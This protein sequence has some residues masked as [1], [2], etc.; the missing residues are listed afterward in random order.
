MSPHLARHEPNAQ[1]SIT[2]YLCRARRDNTD[3]ITL[4]EQHQ[5]E[6]LENLNWK[7]LIIEI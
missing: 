1:V 4:S 2:F 7:N 6:K 5:T 3:E